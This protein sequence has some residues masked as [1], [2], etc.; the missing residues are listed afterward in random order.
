MINQKNSD[1]DKP[2]GV[3]GSE[4]SVFNQPEKKGKWESKKKLKKVRSI[5]L[6]RLSSMRSSTRG[7]TEC[8]EQPSPIEVADASPNYMKAT[9][10]SDAKDSFQVSLLILK[11]EDLFK[12]IM[13][14]HLSSFNW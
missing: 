3:L 1:Y 11:T 9:T 12:Y 2:Q 14:W 5:R 6:H 8:S 13:I 4:E 7:G 10:C